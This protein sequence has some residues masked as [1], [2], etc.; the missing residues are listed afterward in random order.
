MSRL[1]ELLAAP[2]EAVVPL[3]CGLTAAERAALGRDVDAVFAVPRN[4][5]AQDHHRLCLSRIATL[6]RTAAPV[7]VLPRTDEEMRIAIAR[8]R[9][10]VQAI[11]ETAIRELGWADGLGWSFAGV[12]ELE[13]RG[14]VTL[15]ADDDYVCAVIGSYLESGRWPGGVFTPNTASSPRTAERLLAEPDLLDRVFWRI[16]EVDR[17]LGPSLAGTDRGLVRPGLT[18]RDAVLDLIAAGYAGHGRVL[19]ATL[20]ALGHATSAFRAGWF[21]RLHR[22]LAPGPDRT[23]SRQP[24]YD[25]LLRSPIGPV[26]TVG[27]D[28]FRAL[29]VTDPPSLVDAVLSPGK[30]VALKA[31]KL[32][33][34]ALAET[35]IEHP[36][37]DVRA[38]AARLLGRPAPVPVRPPAAP[39]PAGL[40]PLAAV[41]PIAGHAELAEAFA[42]LVE[43]PSDADLMERALCAAARLGPDPDPERLRTV[44]R[45][46]RRR[47]GTAP[48]ETD[49]LLVLGTVVCAAAGRPAVEGHRPPAKT[50]LLVARAAEIAT[51]LRSGV[52][53]APL[54]EP[55]HAGGWID[56]AVLAGRVVAADRP[57]DAIAALLRLGPDPAAGGPEP[58]AEVP[59]PFGAALRHALGGPAP[60]GVDDRLWIA[61][62]RARAPYGDLTDLIA[63]GCDDAGAGRAPALTPRL[64]AD[65]GIGFLAARPIRP[66][67]ADPLLPTV[68]L[69][70]I[71]ERPD[72]F[73]ATAWWPWLAAT[74][75]GNLD[76]PAALAL[77]QWPSGE[78]GRVTGEGVL[79]P[80]LAARA[81]LPPTARVL[82]AAVLGSERPIDRVTA[83][84]AVPDLVP[85]RLSPADLGAA[86]AWLAPVT[87]LRRWASSLRAVA[88]AGHG[89]VV[90]AILAALLPALD[91]TRAGLFELVE[92]LAELA[93]P[94]SGNDL[95]EWLAGFTGTGK[96]AR[97]ARAALSPPGSG[98]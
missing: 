73:V 15:P 74:W 49:V 1:A 65:G 7:E 42:I 25:L 8:G 55:T 44:A 45:R 21:V 10:H 54:A 95:R 88:E 34:P 27:L 84:D 86:M 46:L 67:N 91:R 3:L 35:A 82:V 71:H 28:A 47:I 60:A 48:F 80:L 52:R 66:V 5:S 57:A 24:A 63:H 22:D 20:A 41:T 18:W 59:G 79:R 26:V 40:P 58:A 17:E 93:L 72:E 56:P 37:P 31:L 76:V 85:D 51:A 33:G 6:P 98:D 61:A 19:D 39:A 92:L 32:G 14:A 83:A 77:L 70:T 64:L 50:G 13:R 38:A 2:D 9:P 69:G 97:A 43:D 23:A 87:P 68:A 81:G 90:A 36:H 11:A 96:A 78:T 16:F 12:R 89:T 53:F 75:P 62:A 94:V 30:A 29:R 4:L